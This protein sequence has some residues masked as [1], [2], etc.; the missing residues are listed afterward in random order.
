MAAELAADAEIDDS[1]FEGVSGVTR[2]IHI[3]RG[4]APGGRWL[5]NGGYERLAADVFPR[6]TNYTRLLL[7]FD[8]PRAGGFAPLKEVRAETE[9]VLGLL[10]TKQ[11][12]LEPADAVEMRVLE[13]SKTVGRERLAISPQCGFASGEAGNP[14]TLSDQ[15]AK[16]RLVAEVGR[17]LWPA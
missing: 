9:V 12:A 15:E 13:A 8:T 7:E 14:L 16:L 10:T 1:V 11:G 3:C 6:L 17:K 2:A 5:A 4:N